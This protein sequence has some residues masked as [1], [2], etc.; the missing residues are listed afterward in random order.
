MP[1]CVEECLKEVLK[2]F[3]DCGISP[4]VKGKYITS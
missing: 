3:K 2:I 4:E 1:E